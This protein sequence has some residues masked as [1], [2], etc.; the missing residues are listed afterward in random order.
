MVK[1]PLMANPQRLFLGNVGLDLDKKTEPRIYLLRRII[2]HPALLFGCNK[3]A[4]RCDE[5]QSIKDILQLKKAAQYE[6]P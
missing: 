6:L 3:C 2:C 5:F 1:I 4:P